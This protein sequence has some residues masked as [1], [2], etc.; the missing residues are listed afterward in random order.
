MFNDGILGHIYGNVR[1]EKEKNGKSK[2][3][4]SLTRGVI[5][6]RKMD[7]LDDIFYCR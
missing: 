5:K 6:R 3:V 2:D 1:E 7:V 4:G